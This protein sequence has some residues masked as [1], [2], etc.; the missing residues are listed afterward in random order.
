MSDSLTLGKPGDAIGESVLFDQLRPPDPILWL[1]REG[2]VAST[3]KVEGDDLREAVASHVQTFAILQ[4]LEESNL[5]VV[6]LEELCVSFPVEGCVLEKQKGGTGV[7][8]A[9]RIRSEVVCR[10]S[11]HGDAAEILADGLDGG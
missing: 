1:R 5:L 7:D 3:V 6:H 10:L 8:D 4:A 9:V 11:D 2:C